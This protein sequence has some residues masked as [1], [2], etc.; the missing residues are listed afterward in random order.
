MDKEATILIIPQ[1]K[2]DSLF[3]L[4]VLPATR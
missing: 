4:F 3:N 1:N 2:Q